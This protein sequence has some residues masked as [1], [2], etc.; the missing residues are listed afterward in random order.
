MPGGGKPIAECSN[1][2][3]RAFLIAGS[4]IATG[5]GIGSFW[6]S[7]P[8]CFLWFI[9]LFAF[10]WLVTLWFVA[11]REFRRRKRDAIPE[12]RNDRNA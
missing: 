2:E 10:V 1:Y 4:V 6:S 12:V 3:I 7:Q 9:R 8:A 5:I 11:L